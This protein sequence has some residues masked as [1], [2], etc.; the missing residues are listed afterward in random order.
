MNRPQDLLNAVGP[1]ADMLAGIGWIVL[2]TFAIAAVITGGILIGAA[3]RRRGTLAEHAPPD[4]G[5]GQ[6]WILIGGVAIPGAVLATMFVIT[7][8]QMSAFPLH[9]TEGREHP[10]DIRV[11]G[12]QWWFE[13]IYEPPEPSQRFRVPT[14]IHIPVGR[15]VTL[16]LET[17]DVIHSFWVP[18]LHG[19]VD[20][21]PGRVNYIQIQAD[22]PG[23]YRGECAEFCGMQHAHMILLVVAEPT[24]KFDA[25]RAQ[26]IRPAAA[27]TSELRRQG[28]RV[29]LNSACVLCH[30][31]RGTR[32]FGLAGP[33]LTHVGSRLRIAGGT[34]DNNMANMAAWVTHAQSLKPGAVMPNMTVFTGPELQAVVAYLRGLE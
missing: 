15:P 6:G 23:V 7:L 8:Q 12:R 24:E 26:Q 19:K 1:A 5:G 13:A 16:A 21:I 4:V 3:V 25:W 20:L 11:V 10:I 18:K 14:E 2:I 27:P 34:L 31:V 30:D 33:D 22:V 32:A 28:E 9:E 17:R 29:F